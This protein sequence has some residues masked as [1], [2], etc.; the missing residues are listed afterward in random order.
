MRDA[1]EAPAWAP[2]PLATDADL[3]RLSDFIAEQEAEIERLKVY[4]EQRLAPI[5]EAISK[6]EAKIADAREQ[7]HIYLGQCRL[8]KINLPDVGTWFTQTRHKVVVADKEA[9][10]AEATIR[11]WTTFIPAKTE[12]DWKA[13]E[14]AATEAAKAKTGEVIPGV[15][16]V[17]VESIAFRRK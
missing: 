17:A 12:I 15:E 3:A 10:S 6:A 11:G 5:N 8:Q 7:A 9:A 16:V 2:P 1:P 14:K 4:R 13:I